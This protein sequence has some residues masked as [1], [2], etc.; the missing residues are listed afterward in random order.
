MTALGV[1]DE[2]R[3]ADRFTSD[4]VGPARPGDE[5]LPHLAAKS[6]VHATTRKTAVEA[7]ALAAEASRDR[8][9]RLVE[10]GR[11][12]TTLAALAQCHAALGETADAITVA[13]EALSLSLHVDECGILSDPVSAR[14]AAD[15]LV[16]C[17]DLEYAYESLDRC[18]TLN[19]SLSITLA[20]IASHLGK[21]DEAEAVLTEHEGS[22]VSAFRGYLDVSAGRFQEA[23]H[24]LREALEEEPNDAD[25]L[26]NLSISLWHLGSTRK[27]V[28]AALRAARTA[29]GRK[30]ISLHYLELLLAQGEVGRFDA[31]ISLLKS[32]SVVPDARFLTVQAR[33]NLVQGKTAK[34]VGLL[35]RAATEARSEGNQL[36]EGEVL[37]NLVIIRHE[38]GRL[39]RRE[40][41][42]RLAA[43]MA[44]FPDHEVV[45]VN[46]ARVARTASESATLRRA[47]SRLKG[48]T[49]AI[50]WAYL[51]HQLAVLEG[52]NDAAAEAAEEWFELEPHNPMA[53]AAAIIAVGIGQER[54]SDAATVAEFALENFPGEPIV[55]NNAAY[56]LAMSGRG[57]D[58]VRVLEPI[59]DDDFV[60]NATLGLAYLASGDINRGMRLY[61]EAADMAEKVDPVWRS[62][63]TAY[64]AMVVR[65][66][67]IDQVVPPAVI[68][69]QALVPVE[70]PDDWQER[71][72]FLRVQ[73]ICK[74]DG[75][76]WPLHL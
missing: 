25:S 48:K 24:H 33:A 38:M 5:G 74:K 67:R 7:L 10:M 69:A 49:T 32:M 15:V 35:E 47:L 23:V 22:I 1:L 73:Q 6:S 19:R 54:W 4:Q 51:R 26:L 17:N 43:L 53:A 50:H 31:E 12:S 76:D 16:H 68:R 30:D 46:F 27:A 36:I 52:D 42:E 2:I 75:Y 34:A 9:I 55:I 28:R 3:P 21:V 56:V 72:D 58:A 14:L 29:P 11:T 44:E 8:A 41:T 37:G 71:P 20:G 13:R 63:M 40:A 70:L 61:R 64:Q 60:L 65:Q 45:S 57:A 59:A 62:L 39:T 66:L 18:A